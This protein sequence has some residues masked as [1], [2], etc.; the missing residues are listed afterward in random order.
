MVDDAVNVGVTKVLPLPFYMI[1]LR[2][3]GK[4]LL[5]SYP[6][7][8]VVAVSAISCHKIAVL[9]RLLA[10]LFDDESSIKASEILIIIIIIWRRLSFSPNTVHYF[11]HRIMGRELVFPIIL[12]VLVSH[13]VLSFRSFYLCEK[14]GLP[15]RRLVAHESIAGMLRYIDADC[16]PLPVMEYM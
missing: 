15:M 12:R 9:L 1:P 14:N 10:G 2:F 13:T 11:M 16:N 6:A 7:Q 4:I 5:R 3:F 8:K